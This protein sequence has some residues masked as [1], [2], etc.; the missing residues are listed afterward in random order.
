MLKESNQKPNKMWV[1]KDSEFYN[2]SMKSRL[3]KSD[4][5]MCSTN[6]DGKSVVAERF[7]R[8]LKTH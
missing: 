3:E 8:T 6:N 1:E 7:I 2:R 4:I 5:E